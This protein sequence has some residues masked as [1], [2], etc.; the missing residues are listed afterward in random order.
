MDCML[1]VQQQKLK[2]V[3]TKEAIQVSVISKSKKKKKKKSSSSRGVRRFRSADLSELW[4]PAGRVTVTFKGSRGGVGG[5]R[6]AI[7]RL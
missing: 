4:S 3:P 2:K 1:Q 6:R 5:V 7:P